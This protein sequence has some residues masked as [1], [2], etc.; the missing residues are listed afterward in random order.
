MAR[1]ARMIGRSTLSCTTSSP[2]SR[3]P[4]SRSTRSGSCSGA[5]DTLKNLPDALCLYPGEPDDSRTTVGAHDRS[6]VG[7]DDGMLSLDVP[8]ET[9]ERRDVTG[10][11]VNKGKSA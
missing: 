3:T 6:D 10:G 11:A 8:Y 2:W 5:S 4:R 9:L 1:A 7:D